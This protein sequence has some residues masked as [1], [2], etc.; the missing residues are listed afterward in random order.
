L[1]TEDIDE[2]AA[3]TR[4]ASPIKSLASTSDNLSSVVVVNGSSFEYD[5]ISGMRSDF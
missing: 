2:P 3:W 5:F 1:I 4:A